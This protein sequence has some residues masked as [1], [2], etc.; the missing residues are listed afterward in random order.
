MRL[1][2]RVVTVLA[3]AAGVVW[4]TGGCCTEG[5]NDGGGRARPPPTRQ[6]GITS[7][8]PTLILS[9]SVSWLPFALKIFMYCD[10]SP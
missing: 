4:S 6:R 7:S 8:W 3:L 10:A 5:R 2:E 9:G 1:F